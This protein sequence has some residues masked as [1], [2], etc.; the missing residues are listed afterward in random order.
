[1]SRES[2]RCSAALKNQDVHSIAAMNIK[3][4]L[5]KPPVCATCPKEARSAG[6]NGSSPPSIPA[7]GF[8]HQTALEQ[9]ATPL[10][11]TRPRFYHSPKPEHDLVVAKVGIV[12]YGENGLRLDLVPWQEPVVQ[13]V[14]LRAD[15]LACKHMAAV[16][17]T[18]CCNAGRDAARLGWAWEHHSTRRFSRPL[19]SDGVKSSG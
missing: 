15:D 9:P 14:L 16:I 13:A 5:V 4:P 6:R 7:P 18:R 1:M 19:R 2:S 8:N 17:A 11:R 3:H 10:P 12:I